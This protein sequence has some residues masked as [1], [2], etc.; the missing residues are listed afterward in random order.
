MGLRG[1]DGIDEDD[2][3]AR[4]GISFCPEGRKEILRGYVDSGLLKKSGQKWIPSPRGMLFA[5][6]M[7]RELML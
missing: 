5:D 4:T 2:F 1:I 3:A 6:M 7:A